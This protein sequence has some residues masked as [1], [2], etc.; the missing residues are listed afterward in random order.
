MSRAAALFWVFIAL[1]L[2]VVVWSTQPRAVVQSAAAEFLPDFS[3]ARTTRIEIEW[4]GGERARLRKSTIDSRWILELQ[5]ATDSPPAWPAETSRVQGMLRL[6]A[7]AHEGGEA[8][9]MPEAIFLTLVPESGEPIRLAIDPS[10]LGGTGRIARVGADGR[11]QAIAA[12]DEQFVRALQPGSLES[13]RSKDLLF[14][15]PQATTALDTRQDSLSIELTKSGGAWIMRSP[16]QIKADNG[17]VEGTLLLLS[18]TGVDRFL[19]ASAPHEETWKSPARV[20]RIA[21]R[22]GGATNRSEF[23]QTIEVGGALDAGSRMVRISARDIT[24]NAMLWGPQTAIMNNATIEAIPASPA[25]FISRLSLDLPAA[26]IAGIEIEYAGQTSTLKRNASG[27][28]GNNDPAVRELLR[29]LCEMPASQIAIQDATESAAPS[30][31][32]RVQALGPAN[33]R[34]ASFTLKATLMHSKISGA[35]PVSAIEIRDR[36]VA[37]MVAWQRPSDFLAT[38]R[39]MVAPTPS[40]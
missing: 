24:T 20:I 3:P 11:A 27:T 10:A 33:A 1:I 16:L 37:R 38:L 7:E 34:I 5:T 39:A 28:F 15:P 21:A 18:K 29:L 9:A 32:I 36:T 6:L 8:R 23:E 14:W 40:P 13:W 26:D 17:T 4:P 2:G 22:S 35:P 31:L 30:D 25:A 12:I 19:P